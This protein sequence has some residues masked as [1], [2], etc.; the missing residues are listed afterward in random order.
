ML[1]LGESC[2]SFKNTK[3]ETY[4]IAEKRE[5]ERI[6]WTN[7]TSKE[8][9]PTMKVVY[10]KSN[11]LD[12]FKVY[13]NDFF[14]MTY[15]DYWEVV[16]VNQGTDVAFVSP[17]LDQNDFFSE[18]VNVI[19][20]DLSKTSWNLEQYTIYSIYEIQNN[21]E[22]GIVL[23]SREKEV[24]GLKGHHLLYVYKEDD[25]VFKALAEYTI[26]ENKAYLI[27]FIAEEKEYDR[28]IDDVKKMIDSFRIIR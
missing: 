19:I 26:F 8:K 22:N 25:S 12:D 21:F 24:S 20:Q 14:I 13:D 18:N 10:S 1:S 2:I 9:E 3:T 7:H 6:N 23:E 4:I 16:Q 28:Y 5:Q 15:P 11:S 17:I 27:T